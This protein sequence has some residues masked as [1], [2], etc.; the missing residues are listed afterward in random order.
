MA[1]KNDHDMVVEI[2]TTIGFV[3]E[4]LATGIARMEKFEVDLKPG[5]DLHQFPSRGGKD[6]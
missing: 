3:K 2:Y 1:K 5:Q 6:E 4:S